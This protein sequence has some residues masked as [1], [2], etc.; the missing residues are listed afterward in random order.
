[1]SYP[2]IIYTVLSLSFT[3]IALAQA[4]Q[5]TINEN[6]RYLQAL[7][8]SEQKD[9]DL[10]AK[11]LLAKPDVLTINNAQGEIVW[12]LEPFLAFEKIGEAVPDTVNPS[13]WRMAL[14]NTQ[15]GLFEV[16]QNIYQ[17]RGYDLSVMSIIDAG[18]GYVIVDPLI[19]AETAK[20]GIELMY[21]TKGEKPVL[22]VIYTHSHVDHFGGVRGVVDEADVKSGKI[23]IIAP[24]GFLEHAISENVMAGTAMSRRAMY[25][26]GSLL[27]KTAEGNV[28]AG[29]G[30]GTS[31]GTLTLID[32]TD[33]I[34]KTGETLKLGNLSFEFQ[35]TPDTEAPSEMNFYIPQLS[36]LCLAENVT[37]TLH[38]LYSLRGA[39]VRDAVSWVNHINEALALFVD[40]TDV[41]FSSHHWPTWGKDEI[42]KLMEAQRDAYKYIHDQTLRLANHGYVMNEIAEMITLPPQL[43]KVWANRGYYG[44]VNHNVKA[45]YQRYLGWFDG[46]PSNLH[47]LPPVESSQKTVEYMGGSEAI[48][49]KAQ[50]DFDNGEYRF[51]AEV[52]NHLVFA[53]PNNIKAK[54]LLADTLEQMGYQAESA[55]WRN[56]YLTGAQELRNGVKTQGAANTVSPDIIAAMPVHMILD[57]MSIRL[58][59][60]KAADFEATMNWQFPDIN[61]QYLVVIKNGVLNYF[62]NK[63]DKADVSITLNREKV[64]ALFLGE[65][66]FADAVKDGSIKVDGDSNKLTTFFGM[67]D[68][69]DVWFNIVT[70]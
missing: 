70:P 60:P 2:K 35:L 43:A 15:Y 65:Q 31:S 32:P 53:E 55:P 27:P 66:T 41:I 4:T 18:D 26:Y 45:V 10:T 24:A 47:P 34:S 12:T 56:F 16:T 17:I 67:L 52:L 29:L 23:K 9:F 44:T 11:G 37:H 3:G 51:V 22:A 40:K 13:L 63:N 64:N 48:L 61:E 49:E 7:P 25:M 21:K 39:Q 50:K 20:A 36:A 42:V 14:L 30:K 5:V 46:N 54:N 6:A 57:Y 19:S 62:P 33:T 59:G 8:F 38:N 68:T 28:D 1:M 69:F 58:N